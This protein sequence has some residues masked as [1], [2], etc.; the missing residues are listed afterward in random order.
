MPEPLGALAEDAGDDEDAV[1][2]ALAAARTGNAADA[3]RLYEKIFDRRPLHAEAAEALA[4]L[5]T[6]AARWTDLVRLAYRRIAAGSDR[7]EQAREHARAGEI[8]L[9][10]LGDPLRAQVELQRADHPPRSRSPNLG[11]PR[12]RSRSRR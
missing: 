9:V 3:T 12:P 6:E 8:Y 11:S 7:R 1:R 4:D 5:Y 2:A 10:R